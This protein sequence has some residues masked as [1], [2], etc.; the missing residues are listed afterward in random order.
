MRIRRRFMVLDA[1]DTDAEAAFW[2]AVLGGEV[3]AGADEGPFARWRDVVLD[4]RIELG[5][6]H[7]PDHVAPEWPGQGPARQRQQIHPDIYVEHDEAA[8]AVDEVIDLGARMLQP[9]AD[10]GAPGGFH[11]LADPAGHPFCICWE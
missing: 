2:A 10:P 4:G 7:S 11:V 1:A 8:A 5:V 3:H 9:A 6:Q